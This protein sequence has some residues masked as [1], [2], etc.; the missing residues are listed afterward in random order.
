LGRPRAPAAAGRDADDA[1]LVRDGVAALLRDR[2]VEV[3]ANAADAAELH[4]AVARHLP[5]V[6][7]IDIRMPPTFTDEGLAAARAALR[8]IRELD[9][10]VRGARV[11]EHR[12]FCSAARASP[13]DEEARC[14]TTS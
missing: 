4:E 3:A 7:L 13:I 9:F 14:R 10:I 5:D 6:A 12:H 2:G 11:T 8:P 1:S